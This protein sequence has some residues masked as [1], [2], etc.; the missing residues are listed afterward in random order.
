MVKYNELISIPKSRVKAQII[1][2][3][4]KQIK[5]SFESSYESFI[6]IRNNFIKILYVLRK[7]S[8]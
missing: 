3:S 6:K 5:S 4:L 7:L 1:E 8:K 2:K